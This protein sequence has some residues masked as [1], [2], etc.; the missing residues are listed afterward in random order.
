MTTLFRSQQVIAD[1]CPEIPNSSH[2]CLPAYF[3]SLQLSPSWPFR[4]AP[5]F[6]YYRSIRGF[7]RCYSQKITVVNQTEIK[8]QDHEHDLLRQGDSQWDFSKDFFD[9]LLAASS[10][11]TYLSNLN[12]RT[13]S[14]CTKIYNS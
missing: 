11:K 2:L 14:I 10:L 5:P 6:L 3:D 4:R 7:S 8:C 9:I 1:I 13:T 12:Q